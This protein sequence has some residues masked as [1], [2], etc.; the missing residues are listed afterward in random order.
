MLGGIGK[1]IRGKPVRR[2]AFLAAYGQLGRARWD[3]RRRPVREVLAGFGQPA[4]GA[5]LEPTPEEIEKAIAIGR[6]VRAA[7]ARTP[8]ES[9]CLVQVVAA[10]RMLRG[11]GIG[12][13]VFIGA[14]TADEQGTPG[15]SAHAWLMCG[16]HFV[17]GQGGNERYTVVAEFSWV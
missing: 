13:T 17:T 12:G 15:F 1:F 6:A 11:R 4:D 16:E 14:D 8:W 5:G 2:G 7:A 3:L 10:Q 9:S